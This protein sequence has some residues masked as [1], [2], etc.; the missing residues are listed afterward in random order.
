M[1]NP[2]RLVND[3][4]IA[5]QAQH[6]LNTLSFEIGEQA[7]IEDYKVQPP[8][9]RGPFGPWS[10]TGSA[11]SANPQ[12]TSDIIGRLVH[13]VIAEEFIQLLAVHGSHF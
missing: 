7:R 10:N 13:R 12:H 6:R 8:F 11:L 5:V 1:D 3:E 4:V 2:D 9:A